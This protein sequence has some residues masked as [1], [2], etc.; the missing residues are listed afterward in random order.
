M[1][2]AKR[3]LT[4]P[5]IATSEPGAVAKGPVSQAERGRGAAVGTKRR[6]TIDEATEPDDGVLDRLGAMRDVLPDEPMNLGQNTSPA[7]NMADLVEPWGGS[8]G[9]TAALSGQPQLSL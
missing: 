2:C 3:A 8:R 5:P 9:L 4:Q 1:H 7:M 6:A